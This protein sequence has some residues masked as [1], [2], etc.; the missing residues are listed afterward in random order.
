MQPSLFFYFRYHLI[1]S[2]SKGGM[3]WGCHWVRGGVT[4]GQSITGQD[5]DKRDKQPFLKAF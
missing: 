3:G 2:G 1:H 5:R 4:P